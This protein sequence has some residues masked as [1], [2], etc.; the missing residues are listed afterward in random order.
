MSQ[1]ATGNYRLPC[2]AS[3]GIQAAA[4]Q[5]TDSSET[6]VLR[7]LVAASGQLR[8]RNHASTCSTA[9][10]HRAACHKVRTTAYTHTE[11]GGR[12]NAIG[13]G[14]P[15]AMCRAPPPI[16]RAFRSGPFRIVDTERS[17]T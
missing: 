6:C 1:S 13:S 3:I 9:L 11:A 5:M 12:R 17:I 10:P 16:G 2:L 8:R 15:A 14:F 4:S 7:V